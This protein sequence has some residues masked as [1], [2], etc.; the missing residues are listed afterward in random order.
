MHTEGNINQLHEM[1]MGET[2]EHI[3]RQIFGEDSDYNEIEELF[4]IGVNYSLC[5]VSE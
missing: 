5:S 2:E 4:P 1:E 3:D